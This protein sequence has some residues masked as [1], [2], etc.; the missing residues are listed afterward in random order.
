MSREQRVYAHWKSLKSTVRRNGGNTKDN[1]IW[2]T[3][4]AVHKMRVREVKDII[5]ERK[6]KP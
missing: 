3:L 4:A 2:L 5:A 1:R 6:G